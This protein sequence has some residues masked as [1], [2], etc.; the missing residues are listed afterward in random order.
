MWSVLLHRL[1]RRPIVDGRLAVAIGAGPEVVHGQGGGPVVR[2]R[3]RDG[4]TLRRLPS[5]PELAV[6]ECHAEG[7]LHVDGDDVQDSCACFAEGVRTLDEV[8]PDAMNP[9]ITR[10]IFPGG[11][12]PSLSQVAAALEQTGWRIGDIE[13]W[14]L[15]CA[16]TLRHWFDRFSGHTSQAERLRGAQF[17]RM[18]R[19][20]LAA[21]EQA[22]R[23]TPQDVFQFR[24]CRRADAVPLTRDYLYPESAGHAGA[25]PRPAPVPR[26]P[27]LPRPDT[28]VH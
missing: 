2:V 6:G 1:L 18:W 16:A 25:V 11:Y 14:R 3:L 5:D 22:F 27:G 10:H 4:A 21:S 12:I 8:P 24:I 15:Q 20:Y 26:L 13:C 7:A 9:W 28:S 19:F 23:H 17:V